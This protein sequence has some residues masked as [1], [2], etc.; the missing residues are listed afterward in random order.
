[1]VTKAI[2]ANRYFVQINTNAGLAEP[3]VHLNP[4]E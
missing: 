1:V 4:I 2:L 3:V